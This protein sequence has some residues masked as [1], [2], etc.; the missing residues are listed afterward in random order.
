MG[1]STNHYA[2][3]LV[4]LSVLILLLVKWLVKQR[5]DF[6]YELQSGILTATELKFYKELIQCVPV[7][8]LVFCKPRI[9]DVLKVRALGS[10]TTRWQRAFNKINAKHFDFVVCDAVHLSYLCAIELNDRSHEQPARI[11]RDQF[12]S[13]ACN[14]AGLPLLMYP[15]Q[16]Q[17]SHKEIIKQLAMLID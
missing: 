2:L 13:R 1:V 9:A 6:P 4:A 8:V 11:K 7:G 16:S 15:T 12:V 5:A 3:I 17:Y 10:D 14:A